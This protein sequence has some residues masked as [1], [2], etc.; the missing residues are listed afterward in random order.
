MRLLFVCIGNTC[1][2]PMAEYMFNHKAMELGWHAGAKSSG[3]IPPEKLKF[4]AIHPLTGKVL[5]E[6]GI[7]SSD[8]KPKLT[9]KAL[10]TW[11]SHV[12]ALDTKVRKELMEKG[13]WDFSKCHM[14]LEF[15]GILSPKS[16]PDP[17]GGNLED[18]RACRQTLSYAIGNIFKS[19][20][21]AENPEPPDDDPRAA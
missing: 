11:A 2:S 3:L 5:E 6:L 21:D 13:L 4:T 20:Y 9:T 14:L 10:I 7:A 8:H 1:R 17:L 18:F 15:T 16:V 12:L 19:L